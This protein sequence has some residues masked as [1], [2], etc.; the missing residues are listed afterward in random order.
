MISLYNF[1][2]IIILPKS[3]FLNII[4]W[5][6]TVLLTRLVILLLFKYLKLE[7]LYIIKKIT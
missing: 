5:I 2:I 3:L 6:F 4:L 1:F 7:V